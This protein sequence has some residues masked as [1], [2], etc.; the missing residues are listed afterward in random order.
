MTGRRRVN[1]DVNHRR[2]AGTV[3]P[4]GRTITMTTSK[5]RRLACGIGA[6]LAGAAAF[7]ALTGSAASANSDVTTPTGI[8]V[9][10]DPA[11]A[12]TVFL[13]SLEGRNEVSAGAQVGQ[14]LETIGIRDNTLTS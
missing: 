14:A 11:G 8:T 7:A 2:P 3:A 1:T 10:A 12:P 6:T 9:P 5:K 13:A 4:A